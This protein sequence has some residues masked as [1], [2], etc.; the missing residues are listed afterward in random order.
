MMIPEGRYKCRG[1]E[2]ALALTSQGAPQVAVDIVITEE[3]EYEGQHRTWYGS[4]TDKAT[5]MTLR[6]LRTLGWTG[7]DLSDLSSIAAA[8]DPEAYVSIVHEEDQE[9][10][11]RDRAAFIN[12]NG[13][14]AVKT[15][16]DAGEAKAFA[17]RMKGH[18]LGFNAKSGT[19]SSP[20]AKPGAAASGGGRRP[21]GG[22]TK[23]KT[24]PNDFAPED[25]DAPF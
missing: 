21:S 5:D 7:D 4:F 23:K 22:G 15:P 11:P 16:M 3:G 12:A 2:A 14:L 17:E 10:N 6:A 19:S 18:V 1:T 13:G 9:G 8:E 24:Q 25:G 20:N